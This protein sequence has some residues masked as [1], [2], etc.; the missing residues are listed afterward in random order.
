ML[1]LILAALIWG[2]TP[3]A[4]KLAY[5]QGTSPL[6]L[7]E[8]RLATGAL[9]FALY[10]RSF[11]V[12]RLVS[13]ELLTLAV[14]GL[15]ANFLT[16]HL[17]VRYTSAAAAQVLESTSVAFAALL[18]FLL[19]EE[20]PGR[21]RL[22]AVMAS[23][24]GSALI[25]YSHAGIS[26]LGDALALLAAL[27]WALFTVLASRLLAQQRE[28]EVLL[29]AFGIAALA[30]LPFASVSAAISL[31]GAVIALAM[32]V[33]HTFLAYLLYFRG[34]AEAKPI[35]ATIAFALSPVVAIALSALVLRE[36]LSS[37]FFAG[38]A[39]ILAGIALVR[40]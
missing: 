22:L 25:F 19:R 18:A 23:L 30:L 11:R 36:A 5:A 2:T 29:S 20:M 27:T 12:S 37:A 24:A 15:A 32:G 26:L 33:V 9:L 8:V 35:A 38:A 6:M 4:A 28:E 16:Y 40:R 7:V 39:L 31:S 14:F 3:I 13:R 34:I 17:A 21:R 1:P 10:L